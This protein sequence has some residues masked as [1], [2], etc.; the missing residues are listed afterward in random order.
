MVP[1]PCVAA[2]VFLV[3]VLLDAHPGAQAILAAPLAAS[4]WA[5]AHGL[6]ASVASFLLWPA[7]V[8]AA[9]LHGARRWP[10]V[11]PVR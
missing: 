8:V 2:N 10:P 9:A 4:D 3:P 6:V 1:V 7:W 5:V 11:R